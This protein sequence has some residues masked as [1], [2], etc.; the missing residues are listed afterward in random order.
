[1]L[2]IYLIYTFVLFTSVIIAALLLLRLWQLRKS[3]GAT[4]LMLAI[5]CAGQWS[6]SYALEILN[7]DLNA[8]IFWAKTEFIGISLITIGML[9]FGLHYTGNGKWFNPFRATLLVSPA[10]LNIIL[11][12]TNEYHHGIWMLI[13]FTDRVALGPLYLEH[14]LLFYVFAFYY[15]ALLMALIVLMIQIS[16]RAG[17]LY[18]TQARIMLLALFIPWIANIVYISSLNPWPSLDLTPLALMIT[19]TILGVGFLRYRLMDI[20]PVAHNLVFNAI[21]DGVIVLDTK[22]RVVDVNPV[23]TIIFQHKGDVIGKTVRSIF[24]EWDNWDPETPTGEFT[25]ELHLEELGESN[26]YSLRTTSLVDHQGQRNGRIIILSNITDQKRAQEEIIQ[27]NNLKTR[28]LASVSHDLRTP[29]GSI[30]GY[31]EILQS[32]GFGALNI[33]QKNA[34]LEILDSANQLMAFVN[35]LIGQA[36]IET[37]RMVLREHPF[38]I[39]E[40]TDP[41]SATLNFHASKKGLTLE[42]NIAPDMPINLIGDAYWLRQIVMNLVNNAIK[43]TDSGNVS[44][45]FAKSSDEYWSIRVSDTGIGIPPDEQEKIFQAFQQTENAGK[46]RHAGSGLGL[47]IVKELTAL[48]NGSIE[49]QS[50]V[51]KGSTFTITLPLQE[52]SP[53]EV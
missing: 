39:S 27:A 41:I 25:R 7:T 14:G 16:L 15:Y 53:E 32:D 9:V 23:A 46:R 45:C 33:E 8:K 36:Q 19:N 50:E 49:L 28:L 38:N 52:V 17:Q 12:F 5:A 6:L 48:M 44:L 20:I 47:S 31:A 18:R 42:Q 35:N 40:I 24:S 11:A 51:G 2:T 21:A 4:G 13:S 43:F 3:P 1:M 30:I 29:L 34:S 22:E 10:L 37:G 26:A